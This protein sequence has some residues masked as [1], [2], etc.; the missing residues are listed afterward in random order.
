MP[1][2]PENR[3]RYPPQWRQI[4]CRIKFERAQGRCECE[5]ECGNAARDQR[6]IYA[7]EEAS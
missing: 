6:R 1:T 2:K 7:N 5:G 4:L 3:H